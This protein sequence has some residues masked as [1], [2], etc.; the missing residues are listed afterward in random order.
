M[1][2]A[3][4]A[5]FVNFGAVPAVPAAAANAAAAARVPSLP[6]APLPSRT[7]SGTDS[8]PASSGTGD[9]TAAGAGTSAGEQ[10]IQVSALHAS[11]LD[12]SS[13]SQVFST[14]RIPETKSKERPSLEV[15]TPSRRKWLAFSIAQHSAATFDAYATRRA[16][17]NGA[18]EADPFMKPFAGSPGIYGAIQICPL[19]ADYVAKRMQRSESPLLRHTWWLPQAIGTG[20]YLFSGAHD[21]QVANRL[22]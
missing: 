6:D 19:A 9:A 14:I 16:I 20:V 17:Q 2:F 10:P 12:T 4:A 1:L 11:A 13:N 7:A 21:L 5:L 18:Y 15:E 8:L 22:H 3:I